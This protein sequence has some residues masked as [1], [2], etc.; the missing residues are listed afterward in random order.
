MRKSDAGNIYKA[1]RARFP[2]PVEGSLRVW[3]VPQIPGEPFLWPVT[4][5]AQAVLLMDALAAYDDFQFWQRIKGDYSNTGG[6]EIY[7]NDEWEEWESV[8]GDDIQTWRHNL[9]NT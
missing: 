3:W 1:K 4:H 7:H 5:P 9:V 8:E 6:L 2:E